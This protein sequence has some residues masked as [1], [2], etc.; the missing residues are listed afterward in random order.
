M[1]FYHPLNFNMDVATMI[2]GFKNVR[3]SPRQVLILDHDETIALTEQKPN[4]DYV[5]QPDGSINATIMDKDKLRRLVNVSVWMGIPIHIVTARADNAGNRSVVEEIIN[6][7]DGFRTGRGGFKREHIH[8][9]SMMIDGKWTPLFTKLQIIELIHNGIYPQ[10]SKEAF[11]FVDDMVDYLEPVKAAGYNT[12]QADPA[13]RDHF[14]YIEQ[15]M[16]SKK[17][18]ETPEERC[19]L[20][21]S[22]NTS[23]SSPLADIGMMVLAG[24]VAA[25][26]VAAIA[27]AVTILNTFTLGTGTVLGASILALTGIGLF[28]YGGHNVVNCTDL[29]DNEVALTNFAS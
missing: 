13:I 18:V 23:D 20:P 2:Q 27:L 9:A 8:F 3:S 15:F 11:L 6:S 21:S 5:I 16:L 28:A 1:C 14:T 19:K 24:F 10:L 17:T 25:A 22:S 7:V 29:N 26:G 4:G 12:F